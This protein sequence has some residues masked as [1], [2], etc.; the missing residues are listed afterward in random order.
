[1]LSL[2]KDSDSDSDSDEERTD[3]KQLPAQSQSRQYVHIMATS[4]SQAMS[5]SD[6][7]LR[8]LARSE[9]TSVRITGRRR[10]LPI[11]AESLS[12]FLTRTSNDLERLCSIV[13]LT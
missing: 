12:Y 5:T 13:A 7:L 3:G 9:P 1:M 6:F 4:R 2:Q 10:V 8:L 11:S